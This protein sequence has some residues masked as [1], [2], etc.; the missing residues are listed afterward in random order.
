MPSEKAI[1]VLSGG[2]DSA[3]SLWK[4]KGIYEVCLALT[5]DYGQRASRKEIGAAATLCGLEKIPHRVMALPWLAE[6]TDTALVSRERPLPTLHSSELDDP[7][8]T[9][10]S[11]HAVWVPNRNGLFLNVAACFADQ[12]GASVILTGFNREEAESFPDNS[13]WF[14]EARNRSLSFSTQVRARVEA[15]SQG[16]NKEEIV[17]EGLRLNLP[18][19]KVWS[20][21]EGGE[22]MCGIC[23]SCLRSQRAYKAA[24][25]WERMKGFFG[26]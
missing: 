21:Y 12:S 13:A 11:A 8:K 15:P 25:I 19:E 7:Q 2:L 17:R 20:C 3:F 4:A 18:F 1:A 16:M 5:F 10:R 22:R 26:R 14:V 9:Q 6:L 23:E 24:G